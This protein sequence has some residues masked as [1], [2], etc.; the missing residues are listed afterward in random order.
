M[1]IYAHGPMGFVD[2]R[3]ASSTRTCVFCGAGACHPCAAVPN[4]AGIVGPEVSLKAKLR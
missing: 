1:N 3:R 4:R 2:E